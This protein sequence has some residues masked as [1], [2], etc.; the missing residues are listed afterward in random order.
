MRFTIPNGMNFVTTL[1]VLV[2]IIAGYLVIAPKLGNFGF[3]NGAQDASTSSDGVLVYEPPRETPRDFFENVPAV[4]TESQADVPTPTPPEGFSVRDLS[5][6][7]GR[8]RISSVYPPPSFSDD[9]SEFSIWAADVLTDGIAVTGWRV[10]GNK[11]EAVIPRAVSDYNPLAINTEG[12]IVLAQG[13][14]LT[15]RSAGKGPFGKNFRVNQCM[16]F[17][18]ASFEFDPQIGWGCPQLYT[19]DELATLSGLCQSFIYSLGSCEVPTAER[20][21]ESGVSSDAACRAIANRYSYAECYRRY[22]TS[23]A[24]FTNEWRVFL[25]ER[26]AFDSFHDR[27]LLF[28]ERGLLVDLYTY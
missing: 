25:G 16:G 20:W 12:V 15:V 27:I 23:D 22:R 21:N 18:N 10:K 14:Y 28:D 7:F 1:I 2:V 3:P 8:V 19:Q 5:P 26:I 17:L 9:R 24:F 6:H 11:G 13:D 4:A